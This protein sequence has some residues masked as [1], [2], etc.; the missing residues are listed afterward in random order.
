MTNTVQQ[1]PLQRYIDAFENLSSDN[2]E[3]SLGEML[4]ETITFKDPFNTVSGRANTLTIF[5]HMF[6]TVQSP[7]FKV[8]SAGQ[9]LK[10]PD[11]A[12][13][14]WQ[15]NFVLPSN[16]SRQHIDGMSRVSFD[17]S[18]L[19]TAHIDY[20]DAGEQVY[21]KVPILGWGIRQVIKRLTANP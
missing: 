3:A 7:K 21:A 5:K 4:A 13:L 1:I 12:L 15:F 11:V 19:V 14:Y 20:W 18:G 9:D 6:A 10:N 16:N 2:L 8:I 17:H